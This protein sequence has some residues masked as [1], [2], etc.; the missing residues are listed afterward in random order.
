MIG[1]SANIAGNAYLEKAGFMPL[2]MFELLPLG[3]AVCVI[4][5]LYLMITS[6]YLLPSYDSIHDVTE[7]KREY[8]SEVIVKPESR[9][10]GKKLAVD[11]F[12]NLNLEI[13][14][15]IRGIHDLVIE[16][17]SIEAGDHILLVG[18][19]DD[20]LKIKNHYF[21]D[22]IGE[23]SQSD[24]VKTSKRHV[25]EI[26]I[27]RNSYMQGK[28]IRNVNFYQQ[29]NL[30]V[31]G[32][33]RFGERVAKKIDDVVLRMGDILF[34]QGSPSDI[35]RFTSEDDSVLINQAP[36]KI[37][38]RKRGWI[39]FVLFIAAIVL[40]VTG[41]TSISV[42]F[43]T[44]A[45]LS[46]IIKAIKVKDAYRSVNWQLLILIGGMTSFG[47]AM[48]NSGSDQFLAQFIVET[49]HGSSPHTIMAGFMVLTVLLTQPLS[50]AAAALVML[51]IAISTS[52][53][54]QVNERS[55]AIAII[56][57][58][59]ISMITPFEPACILVYG[60]GKYRF[61]DY[62]KVG[63]LLTFILLA[64]VW[65]MIPAIWPF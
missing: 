39:V 21:I 12:K 61:I 26:L 10:I 7:I 2:S 3:L 17:N 46:I 48:K 52:H 20:L 50:N 65:Y 18:T 58:A 22:I 36:Q 32:V 51:P 14:R 5:I 1:T 60:P 34:V 29:W 41:L 64:M 16:E 6:R 38:F 35:H 28:Y 37:N 33:Y 59:S 27:S 42:S 19:I 24:T 4:G 53:A 31:L 9:L 47:I 30:A 43:M 15:V 62:V 56:V 55:F 44:V 8:V 54:L 23:K 11:E 45:A 25:A 49:F 13:V 40:S 63:G 57:S